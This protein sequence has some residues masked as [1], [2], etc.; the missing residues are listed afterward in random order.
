M[1]SPETHQNK[2]LVFLVLLELLNRNERWTM[3][4]REETRITARGT[5]F[6]NGKLHLDRPCN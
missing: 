1:K 5:N 2:N 4:A 6:M 3:K